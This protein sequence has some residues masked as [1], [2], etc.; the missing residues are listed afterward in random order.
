MVLPAPFGPIRPMRSPRRM[1]TEKS[2]TIGVS[3][4]RRSE[5][6]LRLDHE[7]ARRLR[8]LDREARAP[9]HLA[10]PPALGAHRH[11]RAHAALVARAARLDAAA[12]PRLLLRELLVEERVVARLLLE[13]RRLLREEASGSRPATS[14]SAP[15]SSSRMRV[16][17]R[18]QQRAIVGHEEH[19]AAEARAARPRATGSPRR[20][21]GWSARRAAAGPARRPARGRAPRAAASRPRASPIR[22]SAA[23][24][25]TGE[26][27]SST[28]SWSRQPSL[29]VDLVLQLLHA[30][31]LRRILADRVRDVV[32]LG[33][34]RAD[35]VEAARHH[36]EDASASS[37]GGSSC[38]SCAMR[39][40]G[41]APDHAA[42]GHDARPSTIRS[43]VD[44]PAPLRPIRQT[45]SPGSIWKLAPS[46]SGSDAKAIE[47]SSKLSKRHGGA[48][49]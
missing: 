46:S 5:T 24:P 18:V 3:R 17:R 43:S 30:R 42:V 27:I 38:A 2:R 25:W 12:D 4:R 33:E 31:E 26:T 22:A 21:G 14:V 40:P 10:A 29:R 44:L 34:Q 7:L 49:V 36:V 20:R 41:C 6:P 39:S 1:R 13:R 9:L 37:A 32:V 11:E 8:L 23:S 16:A 35:L 15:R 19:A 48:A 28:R 45:R 47:T